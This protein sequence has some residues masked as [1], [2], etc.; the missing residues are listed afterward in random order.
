VATT[1][2]GGNGGTASGGSPVDDG[3]IP[4]PGDA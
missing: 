4:G 2:P 3:A 1:D